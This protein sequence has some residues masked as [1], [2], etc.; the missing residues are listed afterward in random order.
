MRRLRAFFLAAAL[1]VAAV[2]TPESH[3]GHPMG[4]DRRLVSWDRVVSYYRALERS[5]ERVRVSELGKSTEGRPFL[6]VTIAAPATLR[7]LDRYRSVQ[8]RLADP[9]QTPPEQA[10][11]L[12]AEGKA[13]VMMTCS[14]HAVEV[15]STQAAIEFAYRLATADDPRTRDILANTILLLVPSLNPDGVDR[16]A[17]WY[18][19]TMGTPWEGFQPPFLYQKYA[20]HDNNRDWYF[21]TQAETRLVVSKLYRV[22]HPLIVYDLHEQEP[23]ASRMFLP[24]WVDPIDPNID[25]LLVAETNRIGATMA[26]DLAGAGKSGV[27]INALYDCWSPSRDY[28][29]YH[30][31]MRIL[32]EAAGV[33][34]A[35]PIAVS[36]GQ[37][38]ARARGYNPR[39]RS[40]N[41]PDPWMGGEW[42]LRDIVDY[43]LVA[44]ESML[45]Q[46]A[47]RRSALLR[48][49]YRVNQRAVARR[50]PWAFVIPE[51]QHDPGA[52]R[53]LLE[54]LA[55]GGVEVKRDAAGGAYVVEM[56]QPAS[57]WA[58]TLLERQ[59][60]PAQA[61]YPGGP[62]VRPYDAAAQTVPLLM[63]VRVET[64]ERPFDTRLDPALRFPFPTRVLAA[65]DSDSWQEINRLWAAGARVWRDPAT[66]D[67]Y[68]EPGAGRVELPR[69]RIAVYQG[70]TAVL[71]EGWTRWVLEQFGFAYSSVGPA[72]I[73]AGDLRRRFDALVFPDQP[74]ELIDV[75]LRADLAP[76]EYTGGLGVEGARAVR[77]F[78]ND[79][80]TVIL[81]NRA[82]EY[83]TGYLGLELKSAVAGLANRE[84]YCPG[85]LLNAL[86]DERSPL[87]RGLPRDIAIWSERSPAWEVPANGPA[88]VVVRYPPSGLLASGWLEGERYLAG[89]AAVIEYPLGAGRIVMLGLQP[90][91]RGQSW[92]T[93]KLLFNAFLWGRL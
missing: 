47:T 57:A 88:R 65:A 69:P 93:F 21:F 16:I 19:E 67:F 49:F 20:G 59:R 38:E 13:V 60:Y 37:I 12:A 40:W 77:A 31:G 85:S 70:K 23:F 56:A 63:G 34:L 27:V 11:R 41:Y 29:D 10:D 35:T 64:I 18:T 61:Q 17:A 92:G 75:G 9:R 3:F 87:A 89:K 4:A 90:L 44:M 26:A 30:G 28:A 83:A 14:I 53:K 86:V 81:S 78:A 80:G 43:E 45:R 66:G 54:T 62:P 51:A 73:R 82:T 33:R 79:G 1:A 22:W 8:E 6:A 2:P 25:P 72:E 50:S 68:R 42:R 32:S 55:F 15:G 24:P 7:A 74:A 71:D 91:Y 52:A 58:K 76:P 48:N 46:A 5:S 39:E 84:F 36:P